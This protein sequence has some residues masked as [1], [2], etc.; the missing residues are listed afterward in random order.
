MSAGK[1]AYRRLNMKLPPRVYD[2]LKALSDSHGLTMSEIM[3]TGLSLASLA[4][5]EAERDNSLAV[6]NSAGEVVKQVVL[7]R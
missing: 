5:T 2:E 7:T 4:M 3:R 6:T 1:V